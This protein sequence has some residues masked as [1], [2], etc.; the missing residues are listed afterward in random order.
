[1][2]VGRVEWKK[3]ARWVERMYV[4]WALLR[5]RR[6]GMDE[7]VGLGGAPTDAFGVPDVMSARLVAGSCLPMSWHAH[8]DCSLCFSFFA[9]YFTCVPLFLQSSMSCP[10]FID[11][12]PPCA[13]ELVKSLPKKA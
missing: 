10:T 2:R 5:Y 7:R 3:R 1:M 4:G 9:C 8:L 13:G 11:D 12:L 6:D